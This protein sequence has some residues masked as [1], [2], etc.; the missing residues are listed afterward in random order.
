MP[1]RKKN[2]HSDRHQDGQ[3][4]APLEVLMN[5][6]RADAGLSVE[7]T[8]VDQFDYIVDIITFCNHPDF[9]DLPQHNFPLF[10]GQRVILKCFY[11][12]TRG[13]ENVTLSPEEEKWL[14]DK[15]LDNVIHRLRKM[16]DGKNPGEP[17]NFT[18]NELHL[19]L[20]R[21]ASKTIM[22]S[23]IVAYEAYK[24][25]K[26]G[27]PY[28]FYGIPDDEEIAIINVANSGPQSQRLF[29]QVKNRLRKCKFFR[30]RIDGDALST[31]IRLL[32]DADIRNKSDPTTNI[33]VKGSIVLVCGHSNPDTLR[34]YSAAA[35]L[36]DELAF[37]DENPVVSG[38]TFYNALIPSIAKFT[39]KGDGR[40]VEI[41]S[42]N[43]PSGIFYEIWENGNSVDD[44]FRKT[45]SFRLATWDINE[46]LPY[47]CEFLTKERKRDQES[48]DTEYG[49]MWRKSGSKRNYFAKDTVS[50]AIKT[51]MFMRTGAEPHVEYYIHVDPASTRDNYALAVVGKTKYVNRR[52]EKRHR[53]YL[54]THRMWKP[55]GQLL[56]FQAID[57]EVYDI[58]RKFKT[59][60]ISYDLWNSV[61]SIAFL[62]GKGIIA[63]RLSFSRGGKASFYK[64]LEDLMNADEFWM[65][66]DDYIYGELLNLKVKSTTRGVSIDKDVKSDFPTD[67]LADCIAGATW[68]A[69]G[70]G[71]VNS[72]PS[73]V[74]AN[75]GRT[76]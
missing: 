9:L 14:H 41:S 1:P 57:A 73:S 76:M 28:K 68:M 67:D 24:L 62:K 47:D 52:G 6:V 23:I 11:M 60:R 8:S 30:G 40:L 19:A 2:T 32:T 7:Q 65:Y 20:G 56:D 72:L 36:F 71:I 51:F 75:V 5:K 29:S 74:L 44:E 4:S 58:C 22:T 21:R 55:G 26:I 61:H 63:T 38:R 31:E 18:F 59:M 50:N 25:I 43:Y 17:S 34:G 37:Y 16:R 3:V 42:V 33:S 49:S 27:D 69:S 35:I 13:N 70:Y 39:I 54:A 48:F 64:N 66:H 15:Q 53:C 46:D 12:G 10:L 45:L